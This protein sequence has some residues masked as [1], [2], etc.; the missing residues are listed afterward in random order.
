MDEDRKSR[1]RV[2]RQRNL[3]AKNNKHS[4]YPHKS[5]V[6][7]SRMYGKKEIQSLSEDTLK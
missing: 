3:V 2:K 4:S 5:K 6:A 1:R 7:Y